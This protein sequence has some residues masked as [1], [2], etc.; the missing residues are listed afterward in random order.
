MAFT[1]SPLS[2]TA[3]STGATN[4]RTVAFRKGACTRFAAT[5]TGSGSTKFNA[6]MQGSIDGVTWTSLGAAATSHSST[7]AFT[8]AST[9]ATPYQLGRVICT[10]PTPGA[11]STSTPAPAFSGV[12]KASIIGY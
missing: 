7:G 11:T 8:L 10:I 4:S 5:V 6:R 1:R 2:L 9:S 3:R 12:V